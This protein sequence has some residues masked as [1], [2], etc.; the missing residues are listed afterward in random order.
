MFGEHALFFAFLAY[1]YLRLIVNLVAFLLL[2][3]IPIP[4]N[5]LLTSNDVTVV[6]PSLALEQDRD[7]LWATVHGIL[8]T[9]PAEVILVTIDEN[10]ERVKLMVKDM[11][12]TTKV[13][14][15]SVSQPN[16]RRQMVRAIP[17][18]R[19]SITIFADDDVKWPRTLL[20]WM[21]A[22]LENEAYGGVGT[23][24]RLRRA[25]EPS[26][27]QRVWGFL[28]AIYLLRRN[29]DC[30]ACSYMDG[31][32]PCLSGRTVAYRTK[33][34]SDTAFTDGFT[35]EE[36]NSEYQLN[37]D[38][39]N[40]ITRWLVSHGHKIAFQYHRE[41]E[42]ETTLEDNPK[43]LKQC[44]RWSRSNWR[45]NI[46]SMFVERHIWRQQPW[47]TYAVHLTTLTHWALLW[48]V[49]LLYYCPKELWM[50][51]PVVALMC[52][53][54]WIKFVGHFLRHPVDILLLPVLVIFGYFHGI[55][56]LYA[57]FTLHVTAWGS[58]EGADANDAYRMIHLT[59]PDYEQVL[60][61]KNLHR[62]MLSS[63]YP[64]YQYMSPWAPLLEPARYGEQI[65]HGAIYPSSHNPRVPRG[66]LERPK[67]QWLQPP[68]YDNLY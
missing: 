65:G 50:F 27:S 7:E 5:P 26:F 32:L 35:H 16:K 3:P 41:A 46:T 40:F 38:D 67:M 33:I 28:G 25:V 22:P 52:V 53:S 17:E 21:L 45:S 23:I 13:R 54:K 66:H 56:K 55:I 39:D 9:N 34:L 47:S 58:R 2:R 12:T 30:A 31:G 14:V 59:Q 8:A 51:W 68:P 49:G 62:H 44:L 43:F 61:T 11:T 24:Q 36:W 57:A 6:V 10:V 20:P 64:P 1:R 29:F 15:L 4:E 18:V 63:P 42:V 37:V 60:E 48:D 19:T